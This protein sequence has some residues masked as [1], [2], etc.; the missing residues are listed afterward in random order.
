MNNVTSLTDRRKQEELNEFEWVDRFILTKEEDPSFIDFTDEGRAYYQRWFTRYGY[1]VELMNSFETFYEALRE[2]L[3]IRI[4]ETPELKDSDHPRAA[5]INEAVRAG[6]FGRL[7][8]IADEIRSEQ[9]ATVSR[10][11]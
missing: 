11:R 7:I 10:I 9:T 2:I 1:S 4:D 3:L 6:N 5:E 8:E